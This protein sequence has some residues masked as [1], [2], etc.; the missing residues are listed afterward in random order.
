MIIVMKKYRYLIFASLIAIAVSSC[1][2]II[3]TVV[4]EQVTA[5]DTFTVTLTLADDGDDNQRFIN[6]WSIAGIRV[7]E[8]WKV[9]MPAMAHQGFAEN[10]VYLEDGSKASK[11][12]S[13]TSSAK[14]TAIF[15]EACPK[16][17]YEWFGF[18]SR[19]KVPKYMAACWR[20][21]TDSIRV[22]FSV[23]VPADYPEGTYTINFIGG[24]EE[25]DAGIDKYANAAAAKGTRVF[26]TATFT[27]AY[28]DHSFA[29]YSRRITVK[30]DPTGISA[31]SADECGQQPIYTTDGRRLTKPRRGINI[32][33]GKKVVSQ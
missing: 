20:N 2:K 30:A 4:P 3:N 18:Q 25:D 27:H 9:V 19:T 16:N 1:Y 14:A 11:K 23:T 31:V 10:W 24:D 13:M 6:D 15:N 12:Y 7:P 21:G 29:A 32:T 5:G 17:G 26:H 28:I 8:G 22:S 33:G